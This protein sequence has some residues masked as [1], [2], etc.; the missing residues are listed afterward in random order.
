MRRIRANLYSTI[1]VSI[2][3]SHFQLRRMIRKSVGREIDWEWFSANSRWKPMNMF[4]NQNNRKRKRVVVFKFQSKLN[5][6]INGINRK[7]NWKSGRSK[8]KNI[9]YISAPISEFFAFNG[10]ILL[11][12]HHSHLITQ[13][14][15]AFLFYY[16]A[17]YMNNLIV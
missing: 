12:S 5:T 6:M 17:N 16:N 7:A 10:V 2:K 4:R 9:I 14:C 13:V 11:N 8:N 15:G 3:S 1:N